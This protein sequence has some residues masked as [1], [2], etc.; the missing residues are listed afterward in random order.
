MKRRTE[1]QNSS[2]SIKTT[3]FFFVISFSDILQVYLFILVIFLTKQEKHHMCPLT[4]LLVISYHE[5]C[6]YPSF[7]VCLA[8][9]Q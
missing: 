2:E 3:V 5:S 4:L 9:P 8:E 6:V 1:K 7:P